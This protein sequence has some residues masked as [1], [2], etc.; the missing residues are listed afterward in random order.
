MLPTPLRALL[1]ARMVNR[2]G[3]FSM[4]FLAV[5]LTESLHASVRT[6]GVVV[7]AFGLATIPSRL[8][9]GWLLDRIGARPTILLGLIGCAAAQTVLVAAGTVPVAAVAAVGLGLA[10]ELIEPATQAMVADVSDDR[11]RP[12][13]FGLLFVSMTLAAVL[14]GGMAALVA[15]WDLRVLFAIDAITCVA[16]AVVVRA[17]LPS[18]HRRPADVAVRLAPWRDRRLMIVSLTG[19]VFTT[20]YM[21]AIFGQ[22]LTIASRQV[23]LWVIGAGTVVGAVAAVLAQPLLRRP[24]LNADNGV[25]ALVLG[26]LLLA[27]ALILVGFA[28]QPMLFLSAAAVSAVAD[29]LLMGHLYATVS[30][31]APPGGSGRYLAVFGLSW[32]VATTVAPLV[33]GATLS[34]HDGRVLWLG[35]AVVSLALAGVQFR[36]TR[37]VR[38][39]RHTTGSSVVAADA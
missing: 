14:A 7:A 25:R 15:G 18:G 32:G 29:V 13:V 39:S 6:A 27:G 10:Y 3:G 11:T 20:V 21:T 30:A 1:I 19:T 9:G 33:I 34:W 31:L 37:V 4:A 38:G 17:F 2:V 28:Q 8:L 12:A 35:A 26:Y 16:C 5:L 22:P 36:V 24:K 23:G